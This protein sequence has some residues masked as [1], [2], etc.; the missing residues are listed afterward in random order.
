MVSCLF[1]IKQIYQAPAMVFVEGLVVS[2][3]KIVGQMK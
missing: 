1:F 3:A 2:P